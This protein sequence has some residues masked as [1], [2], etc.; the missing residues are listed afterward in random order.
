MNHFK[1]YLLLFLFIHIAYACKDDK[2]ESDQ[3][4][5]ITDYEVTPINGG[6]IIT[7]AIPNDPDILCVTAEYTRNGEHFTERSSYHKNSIRIEGFRASESESVTVTLYTEN[8]NEIRSEPL[9]VNFTPL[10]A[11][12][13]LAKESISFTTSFGGIILNWENLMKT[14]LNIHL[15]AFVDGELKKDEIYFSSLPNDKRSYRGYDPVETTFAVVVGDKWKNISDTVYYN[16][17]PMFELEV[18]KPW[19]DMRLY[20]KGDNLTE[21]QAS[22]AFPKFF[23]GIIGSHTYGYLNQ[24]L[25]EGASFTFDMKEV[26]KLSRFKFWPSLRGYTEVI[27]VYG[28]VNITE[29]EMWGS[30]VLDTNKPDSYWMEN[31]DP[32][33]TFKEDWE[34]LGYFVR[35]RLDLLGASN[36]EIWQRGAVDGDEF[37]L[38]LELNPVRYIR[39]F[40]RATA[41]GK[42]I[43]NNYWQLGELSFFGTNEIE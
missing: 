2:N 24:P 22:H 10:Q 18:P 11:L 39:F 4:V 26:F 34:Y 15:M 36:D 5:A 12:V 13:D 9:V 16:T 30:P 3:P 41:D 6:A 29:F 20:C 17:T 40:P 32:S 25:S 38:P 33:G 31:D 8:Q 19:G 37:E 28:N 21:L 7:Y 43:P 14:E 1:I 35:E 27:D 23:D 42:P